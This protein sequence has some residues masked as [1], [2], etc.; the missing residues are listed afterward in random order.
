M[1]H[2]RWAMGVLG[3]A[4]VIATALLMLAAAA[5]LLDVETS[6]DD[7]ATDLCNVTLLAAITVA[8]LA[9]PWLTGESRTERAPA[10]HEVALTLLDP[11]P[12]VSLAS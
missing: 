8:A 5:C 7:P 1:S 2:Q 11:P 12:R 3:Q 10:Y 4:A 6:S 9:R